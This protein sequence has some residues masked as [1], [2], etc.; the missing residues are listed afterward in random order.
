[1]SPPSSR[2][3]IFLKLHTNNHDS[4][5]YHPGDHLGVFAG[6]HEDLVNSLIEKLED[7]PPVNQIMKV[8][9]LEERSTA[10]GNLFLDICDCMFSRY[11]YNILSQ[12]VY[13]PVCWFASCLGVCGCTGFAMFL[14]STPFFSNSPKASQICVCKLPVV[15]DFVPCDRLV[16]QP[17]FPHPIVLIGLASDSPYIRI[18]VSGRRMHAFI[19]SLFLSGFNI[20]CCFIVLPRRDQQLDRWDSYS[21][22]YHLSGLQVFPGYH[23]STQP[24]PPAAVCLIGHQWK[25]EKEARAPQQGRTKWF[26]VGIGGAYRTAHKSTWR[27][28]WLVVPN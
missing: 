16:S 24:S 6:N 12:T 1:M 10:L 17:G 13:F 15:W 22:L 28:S 2:S 4:L 3:T 7:A 19:L 5:K 23:D 21:P 11:M 26:W 9:F 20:L 14:P 25:A 8:E 27:G 18:S